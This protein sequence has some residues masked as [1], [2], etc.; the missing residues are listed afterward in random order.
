MAAAGIYIMLINGEFHPNHKLY[1]FYSK[2]HKSSSR[3]DYFFISEHAL[4]NVL[5]CSIRNILINDHVPVFLIL[6]NKALGRSGKSQTILLRIPNLNN[7][8]Q[9]NSATLLQRTILLAYLQT[10][11]G[12][13]LKLS[14]VESQFLSLFLS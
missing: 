2:A 11:C 10:S 12:K 13:V 6:S 5:S 1:T 4:Q 3:I 9:K 14:F 8:L 7:T